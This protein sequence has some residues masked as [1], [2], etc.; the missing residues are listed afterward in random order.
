MTKDMEPP[1]VSIVGRPNVGK[2]S[3]FN[4]I[5]KRRHAV[6]FEKEGT[7]RDRIEHRVNIKGKN[8]ILVD[9]GGFTAREEGELSRLV[10]NQIEKAIGRTD[11]LL[12]LC[13]VETG[14][15]P[16]DSDLARLLRKS[17]KRIILVVN[18]VDNEKRKENLF[19]FY[20]LGLGEVFDI[21]CLHN[22]GLERLLGQVL[23]VLP[24]SSLSGIETAHPIKIAIVGRPNVGKSSFLNKVLDEERAVVHEK[25]GTTRDSVDSYFEKDG[26]L[27][28]LIDTAG[29]RHKRKVKTA[30]D[31]YSMMRARQAIDHSDI[32]LLL[33]DGMEGVTADDMRIFDYIK[34]K[35]RGSAIVVNKWDIVKAIEQSRYREAIVRKMPE[36]RNFP[37]AF[38]SAKT[39][40]NVLDTFNLTKTI[41]T[42]LDLLINTSTLKMFL[43][44]ANPESVTISRRRKQPRF[45]YMV[46]ASVFPKE[47]LVF[48][49]DPLRV[50]DFHTAFIK[51]RLR[52]A[53]PLKGVPVKL[54]YRK[55][56]RT[57]DDGR[58]LC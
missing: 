36:A 50:T 56:R 21:S 8:F 43:K 14:P 28:L 1:R 11:V 13:D 35:G 41:K 31:Q 30:V 47:F 52:E 17:G 12:F 45:Y 46:Q 34:E 16:L 39:G 24:E 15:L 57:K 58:P 48:V 18:K 26:I 9:T 22:R 20:E 23:E 6:V 51:N 33:I 27:F 2:S 49:N 44:E 25:P 42:N 37:I 53:F 40:K 7:T 38:V 10:K 32:A 19:D 4:R 3:L 54:I 29:I 5:I 55:L